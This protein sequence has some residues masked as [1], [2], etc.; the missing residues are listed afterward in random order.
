MGLLSTTSVAV[1]EAAKY[2]PAPP[3]GAP[4]SIAL[5]G[6]KQEGRSEVY[7]HWRF[8]DELMGSLDPAVRGDLGI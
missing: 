2:R 7:R 6:S 1:D 3:K 4:Y 8:K 5:P